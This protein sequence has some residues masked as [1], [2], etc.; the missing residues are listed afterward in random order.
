MHQM[1]AAGVVTGTAA[2]ALGACFTALL[3]DDR[4]PRRD[5]ACRRRRCCLHRRRRRGAGVYCVARRG[6]R[7][8]EIRGYSAC[9]SRTPLRVPTRPLADAVAGAAAAAD[10][11]WTPLAWLPAPPLAT[12]ACPCPCCRLRCRSLFCR[13][14]AAADAAR[15]AT[16]TSSAAAAAVAV[17][18]SPFC[19]RRM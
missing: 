1:L 13:P 5:G 15:T 17:L 18:L 14:T 10:S 2:A 4:V 19:C 7:V 8:F 9:R 6:R 12:A 3:V 16:F 11:A